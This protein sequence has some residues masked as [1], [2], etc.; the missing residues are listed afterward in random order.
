MQASP[1]WIGSPSSPAHGR[2]E[3]D[4][5][6]GGQGSISPGQRLVQGDLHAATFK[7]CAKSRLL[8]GKTHAQ[9]T[10]G[11][12]LHLPRSPSGDVGQSA[13]QEYARHAQPPVVDMWRRH[14]RA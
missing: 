11:R 2:E 13:E 12:R 1:S 7:R 5:C 9:I 14:R 8:L 3:G 10:K 4:L 6:A